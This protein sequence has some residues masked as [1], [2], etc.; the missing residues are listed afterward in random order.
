MEF[1]ESHLPIDFRLSWQGKSESEL[2]VTP[3]L[4]EGERGT[5][6]FTSS[7]SH[8]SLIDLVVHLLLSP[9]LTLSYA[10][11]CCSYDGHTVAATCRSLV[12]LHVT[13]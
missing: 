4:S 1:A 8:A 5:F 13:L 3:K 11:R 2:S 12:H 10:S 7:C 9:S 6:D